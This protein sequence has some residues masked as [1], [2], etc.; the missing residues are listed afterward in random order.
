MTDGYQLLYPDC[1]RK[2]IDRSATCPVA[3]AGLSWIALRL[4]FSYIPELSGISFE[5][6]C[7]EYPGKHL[8]IGAKYRDPTVDRE[9]AIV[10]LIEHIL[11]TASAQD[12]FDF[13]NQN[14]SWD[15]EVERLMQ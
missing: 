3:V 10:T 7:V 8:T 12:F 2:L 13:A 5:V 9:F 6:I 11:N 1:L 14:A 15:R 4:N